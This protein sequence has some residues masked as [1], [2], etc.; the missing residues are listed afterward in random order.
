MAGDDGNSKMLFE[1]ALFE[2]A[3]LYEISVYNEAVTG[4]TTIATT[5]CFQLP[6]QPFRKPISTCLFLF[7]NSMC[8]NFVYECLVHGKWQRFVRLHLTIA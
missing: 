1:C 8:V 6:W 3:R 4:V 2:R 7:R 5:K